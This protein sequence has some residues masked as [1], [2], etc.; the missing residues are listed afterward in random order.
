MKTLQFAYTPDPDD[1][2]HHFALEHGRV[3]LPGFSPTFHRAAVHTLNQRTARG[4]AE[5]TAISAAAYPGLAERYAILASGASVGRGYGPLLAAPRGHVPHSLAGKRVAVPGLT[6]TGSFLAHFF[7]PGFEAVPLP[8]DTIAEALARRRVDAGVLIHEELLHWQVAGVE[9]MECLGERW[10]RT[11]GLPLPVGLIVGRRDLGLETLETAQLALRES[12]EYALGHRSEALD[13]ARRF[14]RGDASRFREDF[15][16]KFANAD[17]VRL[18]DDVREGLDTLYRR[19]HAAGF[20]ATLPPLDIVEH[21][22]SLAASIAAST[23][24]LRSAAS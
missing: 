7:H 8:F 23:P 13:F 12:M 19:A 11:T 5:V 1:A 17:T 6:T 9:K 18:P 21:P 4:E 24:T 22:A 2:F 14:G 15:I 10:Q 16:R 20:L 3:A